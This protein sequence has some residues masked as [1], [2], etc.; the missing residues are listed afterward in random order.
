MQNNIEKLSLKEGYLLIKPQQDSTSSFNSEHKKYD[1]KSIGSIVK[2]NPTKPFKVIYKDGT[3]VVFDDA[4]SIEVTASGSS[5]EVI[6]EEDILGIFE[7]D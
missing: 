1:R 4:R 3:M 2:G 6:K 7:E 5:Y